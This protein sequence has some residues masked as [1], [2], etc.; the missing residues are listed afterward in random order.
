MVTHILLPTDG[1]RH[2][3]Q[4]VF[5]GIELARLLG[6]RVTGLHA[7]PEFHVLSYRVAELTESREHFEQDMQAHAQRCLA[8]VRS[9]A[10][11]ASLPCEVVVERNDHP[12]DAICKAAKRLQCDLIV[13]ASHGR[14]GLVD[15]LLGSETQRVLARS[16]VPVLV[17]RGSA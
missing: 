13:M 7:S 5:Y 1:S 11:E 15:S 9:N 4:A 2:S 14:H 12:H 8:F 17:W 16:E 3:E 10:T 6:A